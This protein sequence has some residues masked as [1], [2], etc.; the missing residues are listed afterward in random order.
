MSANQLHEAVAES[1]VRDGRDELMNLSD[2][3]RKDA[4]NTIL[5]QV[6]QKSD[7]ELISFISSRG[8][9]VS[10]ELREQMA[11]IQTV[12]ERIQSPEGGEMAFIQQKQ[13]EKAS[14]QKI[15][16]VTDRDLP[17]GSVE[18]GFSDSPARA[19]KG[20]LSEHFKADVP[21]FARGKDLLYLNPE[22]NE[23][24]RVEPD[25]IQS[26]GFALPVGGDITGTIGG[27]IIGG[28]LTKSPKGVIAGETIG[29]TA[30]AATG[31]YTRLVVGKLM[32]AHDL[33]N[34]EM[35]KKAGIL[36]L[37]AGAATAT[38]GMLVAGAKGVNN[39]MKGGIF[40]KDEAMK[41]GMNSKE[42]EIVL[43]EVNKIIGRKGAVKGTL[44]RM[45]DDVMIAS[46]EAEVRRLGEHAQKFIER[47]LT[48]QKGL[49]EAL[50]VVTQPTRAKGGQ[51]IADIASKQVSKRTGQAKGVVAENVTQLK[52][53][54]S[55]IGKVVKEMVGEPTRKVIKAKSEAADQAQKGLWTALKEKNGF[56]ATKELFNIPVPVG[57]NTKRVSAIMKRRSKA[58]TTQITKRGASK[59]FTK[60]K[61]TADLSD[62]NREISD[63]RSEIRAAYKNRQFGTPQTKDM[64]QTLDAMVEDRALALTKSGNTRLLKD[65]ESAE[66]AT[67]DFHKTFNRSVIGDLTKKNEQGV[68]EIKS[69]DFVDKVLKGTD[70]EAQQLLNVIGDQPTLVATWKEGISDAYKRAAF[71]G[72]KF[73]RE[74]STKFLRQNADVL[75]KFFDADDLVKLEKTGNLAEKV[76]KQNDQLKRVIKNA[77]SKFGKGKLKS[78]DPENL[79]KFTTNNSG[80]FARPSGQGV[81]ASISKIKYV[82]GITKN[83][84]AAWKAFQDEF[85]TQLRKEAVDIKSNIIS[86]ASLNKV[87]NEQSN[88]IIE[89]MGKE[90]FTSL[91]KIN[92]AVQVLGKKE[93]K[94]I[95]DE[96]AQGIIQSLRAGIAPPL[97]RRGRAFTAAVIFDSKRAHKVITD[98]LLNPGK[99]H[100][101][102]ELSAH[103]SIT[104]ETAELAASLGF[105]GEE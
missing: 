15:G 22:T 69:K 42:A 63:M 33:S 92:K 91:T 51:A 19:I 93:V 65:I 27:G 11:E 85:S 14:L 47:D 40:T 76:A 87:V 83:H 80:S 78:L 35:L 46:K 32:G 36:G 10:P 4:V 60:G 101:I 59:I 105:I 99:I 5:H 82:K 43:E 73:N 90:Y 95:R 84:P 72:E 81:Q 71:K 12:R 21:V 31:E 3:E 1:I 68:F 67:R 94:L 37:K 20:A 66:K 86:P 23:V 48:D 62:F 38:V 45:T 102:A 13:Q 7:D 25:M 18:I 9:D 17:A 70:E 49:L 41:H 29:A 50:D 52:Q 44:G 88:E 58:A 26:L 96:A 55:N 56:D 77:G 89:V 16:I 34:P 103:S 79:V 74:A 75:K 98:S 39:F 24:V 61:K 57:A 100:K 30:G 64:Q 6:S 104:R 8:R 2:S 54:L 53:K 97:T 28:K